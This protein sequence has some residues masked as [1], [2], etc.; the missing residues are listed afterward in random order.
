MNLK[1]LP[2]S[3]KLQ[4][5]SNFSSYDSMER[6]LER[7]ER[8][9]YAERQHVVTDPQSQVCHG[10]CTLKDARLCVLLT[11]NILYSNEKSYYSSNLE[12]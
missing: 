11:N 3:E 6:I 10:I 8:Y 9:S 1:F 5:Y 2:K 7:Y 12:L 4:A